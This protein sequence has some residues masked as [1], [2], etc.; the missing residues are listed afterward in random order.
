LQGPSAGSTTAIVG[1]TQNIPITIQGTANASESGSVTINCSLDSGATCSG[2]TLPIT[3]GAQ[4]FDLSLA[5]A[6][7]ASTGQHQLAVTATF[8]GNTQ[9]L[10]FPVSIVSF[11]GTLSASSLSLARSASGTVTASLTASTGFADKVTLACSGSIEVSCS[12]S[13]P[14]TQ[15][16]G[17]T[18]QSV[19]V[20]MTAGETAFLRSV[21]N[22]ASSPRLISL[23][24][25]FPLGLLWIARRRRWKNL[26]LLAISI[27]I[28]LQVVSCGG[29][30]NSYS[31]MITG[32]VSGTT[33]TATLGTVDVVVTH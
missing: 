29:G 4:T 20:T 32:S 15:L 14:S 13:P 24:A 23:A 27:P 11:G 9:T 5:V 3:A 1:T 7:N 21:P 31:I 33:A 10:T 19:T 22:P 18:P 17:G 2:G 16:T 12:F 26:L 8:E 6:A 30:S 28:L 25:L